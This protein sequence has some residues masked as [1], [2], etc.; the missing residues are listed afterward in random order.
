[1]AQ[2]NNMPRNNLSL[3]PTP[4]SAD[5]IRAALKLLTFREQNVLVQFWSPRVVGKH[6]Q[7]TTEDQP[8]GL[9]AIDDR[10]YMYRKDSERKVY[11]VDKEKDKDYE[12][13]NTSPP[14]RVFR[15]RLPEWT[16]DITNY[17]PKD[18]PQQERAISC[19]LRGYLLTS[20]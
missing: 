17:K 16:A 5:N 14:A 19:D 9:G 10:L 3:E 8:Y 11:V 15:Q 20:V 7:L 6:H 2:I 4:S 13:E 1:M 12:E 18:F